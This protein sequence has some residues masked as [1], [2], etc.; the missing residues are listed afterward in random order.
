MMRVSKILMF[1]VVTVCVS[2]ESPRVEVTEG[3]LV[4]KTVQFTENQ[5]INLTKDVDMFLGV[6]FAS[7][8]TR[9]ARADPMTRWEGERNA[10]E[11]TPA[12]QQVPQPLFY[13]VMSEDC[14]YLNVYTPSPKPST[15]IPVM[16]WIHG[17][18]F[19]TG[20]SMTYDYY[21]PPLVAVGD[22][23]IVTFNYRLAIFAQLSTEDEE[24]PGNVGML[25]Q[26]AALEWVYNNIEAFGGDKEQITIFGESAG[27]A[28]VNFHLL[29][30]LSKKF[31]KQAVLQSGTAFSSWAFKHDPVAELEKA[32][33]LGREMGCVDVTSTSA[34]VTCLRDVED[35]LALSTAADKVYGNQYPVTMDG[36]FLEDT[37]ANLYKKNDFA[38]VPLLIGFNRDEGTIG[39]YFYFPSYVGSPTPPPMDRNLFEIFVKGLLVNYGTDDEIVHD[40]VFQ[41]YIDWAMADNPESD[42]FQSFVNYG[43]DSDY[44]CPS[45]IVMR[46]HAEAGGT[47]YKYFMT[48]AP[49][50]SYFMVAGEI[51][52]TPWLG[53]GHG[54]DL[55]FVWGVPFIDELYHIHGHNLTD[56]ENA[57]SVKFMQ[58]WTNFAKSGDPGKSIPGA[59]P[60]EGDDFW[61]LYTIPELRHKVLSPS[62]GEDRA[63]KAREC[64]FWANY[65]PTLQS[66]ANT[67]DEDQKEWRESYD[68]W[69]SEMTDW[70]QAFEKYKEQ[71][72]CTVI[73]TSW[74]YFVLKK[75]ELF[76]ILVL[77][78]SS[79]LVVSGQNPRVT[80]TEGELVGKTVEFSEDRFINVTKN[81]DIY[82]GVPYASPPSRF[83]APG[84]MTPWEGDRNATQFAPACQQA[85]SFVYPNLSE[86][87]LYLNVYAP[88]P[89]GSGI[90]VMVWIH[91]GGFSTGTA[92]A[93]DYYGLPL[94]AVGDVVVVT[95]NYR[96]AIFAQF[97]TED[98][99]SPGNYGML[100]QVAALKWVYD[101][102]EAF[103]G[104]KNKV[105]IFGESAGSGSVSFHII[106]KLS[107]QY[108]NQAIYQSG[109]VFSP[110]AFKHDPVAELEKA[111]QLGREMGC[112][113][114][115][116]NSALVSCLRD[117][118]ALEL[119][120]AA[121]AIYQ[122]QY[123]V[124]LDGSFLDD[125]PTNLYE[126]GD[127]ANV[128]IMVGFN[129]DE[130]TLNPFFFLQD[131]VGSPTPPPINRT[132]FE[133]VIKAILSNYGRDEEIVYDSVLQEYIDWTNADDPEADYFESWVNFGTDSDFGCPSDFVVRK[134]AEAGGT[135]YKYY[136]T[137]APSKSLFLYGDILPNTPWLG[138]GHGEDLTFVWG[139]PFI[140]EL[141][142]I[143]GQNLTDEENALSVKFMQFWTN[144]AKSG[145]P[146]KSSVD[147]EAGVG[148]DSWPLYTI[149]ELKHKELSL[150]LGEGRAVLARQCHFW[151]EYLPDLEAFANTIDEDQKEWREGYDDWKDE[152]AVWEQYFEEYKQLPTC[153]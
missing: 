95:I 14:L 26:V 78:V 49:S 70:E 76:C 23:I 42:Y 140:D 83:A 118:D 100:D 11:F 74:T 71:P 89:K 72:T 137:H 106:S 46:K 103:G 57:L 10:T 73:T 4:G 22:V 32:Q 123:P 45:D 75:M 85:P 121:D 67:I 21:G 50:K 69:K 52:N 86:D 124:T 59:E 91:G 99:N 102:I 6:P 28:S 127:F 38:N 27:S 136:M 135:V 88:S 139:L 64:R 20:T 68:D 37:P 12:C 16:V 25:D 81:V 144:F 151:N 55:T 5:Y 120:A 2:G 62:F 29:S 90:P 84:P 98:E 1:F 63:L 133:G 60:G 41:E 116:S 9:F 107:R 145:D 110:W 125:T 93:Y 146:S 33:E 65:V 101:N 77:F 7:P 141:Y 61:P 79:I 3:I 122:L 51:P 97:S 113:D 30:K 119:S 36:T 147:G 131:Y 153:S 31:F 117:A 87:C 128:P 130:G 152:M 94:V 115:I 134:H 138:A 129:K 114:V 109:T 132:Y 24:A 15:G 142:Y 126:M 13:P 96:L 149:P 47:V 18:A 44:A 35:P 112:D 105:T 56:E 108:F 39:P 104:D 82:L 111:Q 17:G 48:H 19:S 66:F 8:P 40:A 53:A 143:H 54:E 150:E 43:T 34:L 92:M 80:V 148:V 58:F